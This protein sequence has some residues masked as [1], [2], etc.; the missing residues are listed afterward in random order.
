VDAM[1]NN[2]YRL[3]FFFWSRKAYI[4]AQRRA[5][6]QN[7]TAEAIDITLLKQLQLIA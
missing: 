5:E 7:I 2:L 6:V 1:C 3:F 4:K